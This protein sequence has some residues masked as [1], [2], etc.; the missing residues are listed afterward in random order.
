MVGNFPGGGSI[1]GIEA[2]VANDA[3][4]GGGIGQKEDPLVLLPP[5]E[6]GTSRTGNSSSKAIE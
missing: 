2:N 1:V 4:I 3:A 6:E 5:E